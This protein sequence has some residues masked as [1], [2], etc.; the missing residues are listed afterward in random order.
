MRLRILMMGALCTLAF[1]STMWAAAFAATI[2]RPAGSPFVIPND[3]AGRPQPF[4]VVAAG[5]RPGRLAY[6]EQCDGAPLNTPG[7]SPTVHCDLGT[8]P[9]PVI[10]ARDGRA[11]FD[12]A[13]RNHAFHPFRG[14]SPQSL[15]NC[16]AANDATPPNGLPTF[17][18]CRIRVSSNNSTATDDQTFLEVKLTSTP[19]LTP[20]RDGAPAPAAGAPH[21]A[22][23]SGSAG[24]PQTGDASAT[25]T[26]GTSADMGRLAFTGAETLLLIRLGYV[27][28][29]AGIALA[30]VRRSL[31]VP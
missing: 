3:A 9:A 26:S 21:T 16:L 13:D 12:I 7:W 24:G 28:V 25:A 4:S 19:G 29:V 27:L 2:V 6:V 1:T 30:G 14:E 20:S 8:A 11:T 10:V 17:T 31:R 23:P 5:L 15:F 18:R 22:G